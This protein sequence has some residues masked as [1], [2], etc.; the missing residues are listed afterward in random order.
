MSLCA[1]LLNTWLAFALAVQC[2]FRNPT[3]SP[4][5]PV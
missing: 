5:P 2:A 3:P 4:A 1:K